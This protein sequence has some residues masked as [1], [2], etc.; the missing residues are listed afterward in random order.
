MSVPPFSFSTLFDSD[1]TSLTLRWF[2]TFA[3]LIVFF[4]AAANAPV[5]SSFG[6]D[7][8]IWR[9]VSPAELEMKTPL[10]EPDADA[11]AIFWEVRVDDKKLGKLSYRHYVRVK[12]FTERGRERFAKMDIPFV[13]GK[14][15]EDVAARVIK[16]DGSIIE[17]KP[18]DIFDRDIAKAGK[19]RVQ[20]KSFAVPGIEPGV[21][22]EYQY[23][24][25]IKGDSASG[26]R[27]IFQRDIPMQK[28]TYSVRPYG[29]S[30]LAFNSYN[31]PDTKFVEGKD[32]F[33]TATLT[34][35]LAYKEEPYMPPDDEVRK[36]V[37]LQYQGFGTL[38]QW[39][40]LGM[41]WQ[42]LIT[43]F[44][45]PKKDIRAKTDELTAGI[46]SEEEKL[47]KIYDFVQKNIKNIAF[48]PNMTEDRYDDLDI[49]SFSDVLK[50][51]T[52]TST[53]LD[54]LFASLARAAGFEVGVLFAGDRSDNFFNP[55]KYPFVNFVQMSAIGV[56][57]GTE[58]KFFDPCTPYM[59]FGT[60]PWQRENVRSLLV[61]DNGQTW[62]TSPLSDQAHSPAKR[63][64]KLTLLPDGTIEGEIKIEYEGHPAIA[65]RRDQFK[66][67]QP[68]REETIKNE[69]KDKISN[70]EI[71][72]ISI[73]NFDDS[74]KPLTYIMKVRVPNYA[75]KA[76]K[77][78]ILQPGFFEYG[79]RPVFSSAS[80]TNSIYFPYPWSEQDAISIKLPDGYEID[81]ADSP[82]LI[83]DS[84]KIGSDSI[85]M[86]IEKS[87]NIL[88]Y[89]RNFYFGGGGK[90]LFPVT[91]YEPL[92][93]LFDAF[94]KADTHAISIKQK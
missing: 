36:W 12:I 70:A 55:D 32:G 50:Q 91:A 23:S 29:K 94:H 41:R 3:T 58:W 25:T 77:R 59:P 26:E 5:F 14:K 15:V 53:H 27:L 88:Y 83:A 68:K 37:Y 30:S 45:K 57:V 8:P 44:N 78:M 38:L 42:P 54:L 11:E 31:M 86:S 73:L 46:T 18:T 62:N 47:R 49:D 16:P 33:R 93:G 52:G 76:G 10:V 63:T 84:S 82:G 87:A 13:K 60:L 19:V 48:D 35:V 64:G 43:S 21:I 51:R 20:A 34:N 24:E 67:S 1:M 90:I 71:S 56:K 39:G 22:V 72:N 2:R 74:S 17:L 4:L 66:D 85:S 7:P 92:K 28:V 40:M 89:R 65:R 75:Q 69:I 6:E 79:A 80:R 81:G 9:S 61:T